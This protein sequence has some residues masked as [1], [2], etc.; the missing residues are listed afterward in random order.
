MFRWN[1][2]LNYASTLALFYFRL[3]KLARE[4]SCQCV[5]NEILQSKNKRIKSIIVARQKLTGLL[6]VEFL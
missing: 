4:D 5:E 2:A 1:Y 3:G 6:E